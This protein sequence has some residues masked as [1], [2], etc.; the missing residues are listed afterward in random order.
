M[1]CPEGQSC[2]PTFCVNIPLGIIMSTC[3]LTTAGASARPAAQARS[4]RDIGNS[5]GSTSERSHKIGRVSTNSSRRRR[6]TLVAGALVLAT[7]GTT[8]TINA[9]RFPVALPASSSMTARNGG[10][11]GRSSP[12]GCRSAFESGI[13]AARWGGE[14][15]AGGLVGSARPDLQQRR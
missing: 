7:C 11:G 14:A 9:F 6:T 8:P 5:T 15:R 13:Q 4:R 2:P 3:E 10:N 1:R 12:V